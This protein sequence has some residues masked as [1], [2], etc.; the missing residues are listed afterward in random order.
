MHCERLSSTHS[1]SEKW[2]GMGLASGSYE[3]FNVAAARSNIGAIGSQA[4]VEGSFA[5]RCPSKRPPKLAP[6]VDGIASSNAP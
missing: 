1:K 3:K 6:E 2:N 5:S 4:K